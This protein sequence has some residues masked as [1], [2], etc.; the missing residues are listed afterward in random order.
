MINNSSGIQCKVSSSVPI[1]VKNKLSLIHIF[2]GRVDEILNRSK[3][4]DV[5][6]RQI[7][8]LT[9]V[10]YII[11]ATDNPITTDGLFN[12]FLL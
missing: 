5:Y 7:L 3:E 1:E 9:Y 6:K 10:T 2:L 12:C 4:K 11:S 8:Y